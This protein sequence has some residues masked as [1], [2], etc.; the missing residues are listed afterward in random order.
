[1]QDPTK[2]IQL[3]QANNKV[4]DLMKVYVENSTETN[5]FQDAILIIDQKLAN[6]A[7]ILELE[8]INGIRD[9]NPL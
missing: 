1:M 7:R 6:E 4:L 8:L 5:R 9:I 2:E 3:L